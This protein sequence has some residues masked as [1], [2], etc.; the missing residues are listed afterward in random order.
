MAIAFGT[1]ENEKLFEEVKAEEEET[2]IVSKEEFLKKILEW[3]VM[4]KQSLD[5]EH[6]KSS[7]ETLEQSFSENTNKLHDLIGEVH[8]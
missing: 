2:G 8:V 5:S 6:R 7:K 4:F 3:A 1:E